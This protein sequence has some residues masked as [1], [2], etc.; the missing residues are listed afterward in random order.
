MKLYP[1]I[2]LK[3]TS[4]L[5]GC[6]FEKAVV[7][8]TEHNSKGAMGFVVNKPFARKLNELQEFSHVRDFPLYNGGP[9]DKEHLFFIH[10]RPDVIEDGVP[11]CDTI[12][13]GGNFTQAVA[14][15]N[16]YTLTENDIKIFIGYCGWDDA[17]LEA[18]VEEGSWEVMDAVTATI[19]LQ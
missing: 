19:F 7:F 10:Q 8:I 1:G 15:I 2:F 14:A 4:L 18:E 3:S 17:E 13:I 11:V 6:D 16:N 5:D 12:F 9:V